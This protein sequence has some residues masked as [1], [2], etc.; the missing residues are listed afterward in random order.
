VQQSQKPALS[1]VGYV[2]VSTIEQADSDL[3]LEA[4][5]RAIRTECRRR[6]WTLTTIEEDA[7]SG[8]SLRRPG[9]ER[10]I[11]TCTV[12]EAA[13]L[14]VAK[15]DRLTRSVVDLGRLLEQAKREQ[16][17]LVAL[18]FGLDF[19]TPQG[20]LVANVLVSVSQ[21]ERRIIGQRTRDALA[22]RRSQGVRLGRAPLLPEHVRL[23]V[24][25]LR[26]RGWTLQRIADR[27]NADGV[28]APAGGS[29]DRAAV[30]RVA[31][32]RP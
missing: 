20:E 27:L 30:R 10:A 23:H 4:Q 11:A 28:S 26:G 18:D 5:R 6:S 25:Q 3:G 32:R 1:V 8:R 16:W 7:L 17:N 31:A 22:V 2:R 21:W 9:L 29:W 19:S 13:G 15:L 24:R 14:V 12:G